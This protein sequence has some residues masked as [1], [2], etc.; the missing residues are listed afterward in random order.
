[1]EL[2]INPQESRVIPVVRFVVLDKFIEYS[3]NLKWSNILLF[4]YNPIMFKQAE[5][6]AAHWIY[7]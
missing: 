6:L 1:M 4:H 3:S 2:C 7:I 5:K